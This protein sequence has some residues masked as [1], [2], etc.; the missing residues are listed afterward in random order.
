MS[1]PNYSKKL[2]SAK[3]QIMASFSILF[4]VGREGIPDAVFRDPIFAAP[5]GRIR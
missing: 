4:V 5:S 2:M 3:T 1:L